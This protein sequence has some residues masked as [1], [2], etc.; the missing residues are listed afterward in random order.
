MHRDVARDAA[1]S[2]ELPAEA[3][4]A[5][6]VLGD[7]GVDLAVGALEVA[8]GDER[9]AAVAGAGEVDHLLVGLADQA[10][11]V[12]VDERQTGARAPVAEQARLDVV[13]HERALEQRVR[14]QVDL[15]DGQVVVGAPPGVERCDLLVGGVREGL[16]ERVGGD[17]GSACGHGVPP[18]RGVSTGAR[19]GPLQTLTGPTVVSRAARCGGYR[20]V[21]ARVTR[22]G[23]AATF[24]RPGTGRHRFG[25]NSVRTPVP[26]MS[27]RGR[28]VRP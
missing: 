17:C 11:G 8:R 2:G 12:R 22:A 26:R 23:C 15:G 16:D 9:R 28:R 14:A 7:V 24:P 18:G 20:R 27:S 6:L 1:G 10:R 13:R 19:D 21:V 4:Q 3:Q 25:R 5:V